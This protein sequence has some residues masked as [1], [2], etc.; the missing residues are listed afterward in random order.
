LFVAEFH[1]RLELADD[2]RVAPEPEVSVNA[3]LRH[4]Q[5]QLVEPGDPRPRERLICEFGQRRSRP[6]AKRGAE[7][8][9]R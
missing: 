8:R 3:L 2:V 7:R 9:Y 6:R 5:P 1:Q 4:G